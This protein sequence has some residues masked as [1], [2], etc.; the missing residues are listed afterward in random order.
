MRERRVGKG[1]SLISFA[2]HPEQARHVGLDKNDLLMEAPVRQ[3]VLSVPFSLRY[4]LAYDSSLVRDVAQSSCEMS[5]LRSAEE[6]AFLYQ[7]A[8]LAAVP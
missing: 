7:T 6:R 2:R 1:V 3:W 5:F 4:R 8:R